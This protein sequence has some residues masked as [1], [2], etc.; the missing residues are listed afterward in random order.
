MFADIEEKEQSRIA[1]PMD[2]LSLLLAWSRVLDIIS[3]LVQKAGAHAVASGYAKKKESTNAESR[4]V[5]PAII[6]A[7]FEVVDHVKPVSAPVLTFAWAN[8]IKASS[9]IKG[10]IAISADEGY[11]R[12][13]A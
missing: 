10:N 13:H 8:L 2:L 5:V 12:G 7:V 4:L 9:F 11:A 6:M 3:S 1:Y